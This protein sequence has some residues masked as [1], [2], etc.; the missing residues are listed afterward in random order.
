MFILQQQF[1]VQMICQY[2]YVMFL[3]K[4]ILRYQNAS[5]VMVMVIDRG[6]KIN[7][8]YY[9]KK[10]LL[11]AGLEIV[12]REVSLLP[13]RRSFITHSKQNLPDFIPKVKYSLPSSPD[14]NPLDFSIGGYMAGTPKE[15]KIPIFPRFQKSH[16]KDLSSY[17]C[18]HTCCMYCF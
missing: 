3:E 9:K 10:Y 4:T 11:P 12:R 18:C 5:A 8:E 6:V 15:L 2:H 7:D 17:S 16:R 1:N 13:A 14:L